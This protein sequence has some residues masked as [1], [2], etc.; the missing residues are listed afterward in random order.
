M[1]YAAARPCRGHT[2]V[3]TL[4]THLRHALEDMGEKEAVELLIGVVDAE[5]LEVVGGKGFE[6]EDVQQPHLP[7]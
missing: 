3:T 5:L 6:A 1:E 4:A 7:E 2:S